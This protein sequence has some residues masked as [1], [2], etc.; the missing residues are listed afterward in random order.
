MIRVVVAVSSL[1]LP[2]AER[3]AG[4]CGEALGDEYGLVTGRAGYHQVSYQET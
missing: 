2:K 4:G 1:K 3:A